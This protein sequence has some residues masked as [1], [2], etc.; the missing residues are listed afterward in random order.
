LEPWR[1]AKNEG[2]EAQ[3]EVTE[4][5][6]VSGRNL[7]HL[8]MEQDQDPHQRDFFTC[9]RPDVGDHE[10]QE[11]KQERISSWLVLSISGMLFTMRPI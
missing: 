2:V 5:L 7:H 9:F 10:L 1:A 4:V 3:N 8:N 6:Y 11:A